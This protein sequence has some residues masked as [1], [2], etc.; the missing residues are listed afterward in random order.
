MISD[1]YAPP[2]RLDPAKQL[3]QL[4][5]VEAGQIESDELVDGVRELVE[6]MRDRRA[7]LA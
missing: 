6:D 4:I 5:T 7:R 1:R 2:L 3:E